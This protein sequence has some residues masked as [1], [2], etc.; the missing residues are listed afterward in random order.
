MVF[1]TSRSYVYRAPATLWSAVHPAS[2]FYNMYA[3]ELIKRVRKRRILLK[4]YIYARAAGAV[5]G[6]KIWRLRKTSVLMKRFTQKSAKINEQFFK[7][8]SCNISEF[9]NACIC[10]NEKNVSHDMLLLMLLPPL[11][12]HT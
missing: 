2:W 5:L 9:E 1:D 7:V 3:K 12:K 8:I 11:I 10:F 6:N 4:K